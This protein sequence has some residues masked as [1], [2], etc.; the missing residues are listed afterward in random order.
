MAAVFPLVFAATNACAGSGD[1]STSS[2]RA[3]PAQYD[4]AGSLLSDSAQQ[5]G[6]VETLSTS[7]TTDAKRD[8]GS[9]FKSTF[10]VRG[11]GSDT[12]EQITANGREAEILFVSS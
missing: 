6:A 8:D 10:V 5:F 2:R 9:E 4:A 12:Y 7:G 11:V 1:E 3:S